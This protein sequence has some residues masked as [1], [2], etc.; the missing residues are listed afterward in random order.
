MMYR[1]LFLLLLVSNSMLGFSQI[2]QPH[3]QPLQSFGARGQFLGARLTTRL[4]HGWR[5]QST[6]SQ[7]KA[8]VQGRPNQQ[9]R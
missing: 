2:S 3:L 9:H 8:H 1:Y 4:S 5:D 7:R 6:Q